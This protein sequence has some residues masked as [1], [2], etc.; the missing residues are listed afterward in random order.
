[1]LAEIPMHTYNK[2]G[3][4]TI[5]LTVIDNLGAVD[6]EVITVAVGVDANRLPVAEPGGPYDG[7][8][9]VPILFDVS[10]S[11]DENDEIQQYTW[12]FGDGSSGN[13]ATI[14]HTY[15]SSGSYQIVLTVTDQYG[16]SHAE[17]TIVT[18][19][20]EE[21]TPGFDLIIVLISLMAI[22][23]ITKKKQNKGNEE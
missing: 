16:E 3:I 21:E 5:T 6:S 4:Y 19:Q 20:A 10:N 18:I 22:I 12:V 2:D 13:G 17:T 7:K 9:N 1:M 14:S 15:P 23:I 11:Y 8:V